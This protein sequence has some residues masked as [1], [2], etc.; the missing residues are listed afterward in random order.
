MEEELDQIETQEVR[1]QRG[2]RRVLRAAS[3]R[4]SK[5]AETKML[6]DAEKCPMCGKPLRANASASSAS[7]SAARGYPECKYIK[8]GAGDEPG[9]SPPK[10]TEHKC[11]DCGKPMLA[12]HGPARPV[13]GLLRLPRLQDDDELRRRGQARPRQPSRPSTS[14]RSAASRW[15]CAKAA[16]A[17]SSPAPAIPK[18]KNAKDVDAEGEPGQA[19]RHRHRV[20]EVRQPDGCSKGLRGPFLGCSAYPK[21][22]STEADARRN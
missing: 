4:P 7:S 1:A 19:D 5:V 22:R 20:R 6:A 14:A 21:C 9:R 18:C 12:A 17:R 13:P 11:P 15:C 16:A 3:A 10:K 8:K 2:A